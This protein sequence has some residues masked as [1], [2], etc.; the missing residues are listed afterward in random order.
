MSERIFVRLFDFRIYNED[1]SEES[2]SDEEENKEYV[3]KKDKKETLIQMFG[4]NEEGETFA[5]NVMNFK[6]FFYVKVPQTWGISELKKFERKVK[7]KIGNYY[8]ESVNK[9]K[10]IK[11]KK[12]YGFDN[13]KYYNFIKISFKNTTAYN[14][15]KALW[16]TENEDFRKRKLIDGGYDYEKTNK[17]R[18]GSNK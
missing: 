5:I 16:Y 8:S 4:M 7:K 2:D 18:Q 13:N 14:K 15:V 3:E 6:P 10:L 1:L 9:F 12:L 11:K 17:K